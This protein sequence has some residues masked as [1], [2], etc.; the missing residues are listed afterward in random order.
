MKCSGLVKKWFVL[1][2][3]W[4][5]IIFLVNHSYIIQKDV[6]TYF[7]NFINKIIYISAVLIG[8]IFTFLKKLANTQPY[9]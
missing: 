5:E 1:E 7:S 8:N 3:L 4:I 6:I 2:L 9:K